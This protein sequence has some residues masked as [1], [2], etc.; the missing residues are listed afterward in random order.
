M[1]V[2]T[3]IGLGCVLAGTLLLVLRVRQTR[4]RWRSPRVWALWAAVFFFS[5]AELFSVPENSLWV[6]DVTG[7]PNLARIV[8]YISV[9]ATAVAFLTL[10]LVWRYPARTAWSKVRGLLVVYIAAVITATVLFALSNVPEERPED[11]PTHY[12]TQPTVVALLMVLLA[13]TLTSFV[14][15]AYWCFTWAGSDDFADLPHLRV[16]LRLYG[17]VGVTFST[18]LSLTLVLVIAANYFDSDALGTVYKLAAY[19][20]PLLAV[21]LLAAA[22]VVPVWGRRR[23]A[24]RRWVGQWR[25]F[26]TLR[27]L[28]RTLQPVAPASV[29]VT[30]GKTLDPHHRVRR[31]M[32]ELNDWRTTLSPLFDPAVREA[33][34]ERGQGRG[35]AG[36]QLEALVEAA[37]L[38]AATREW[39]DGTRPSPAAANP[40]DD[41]WI[42]DGGGSVDAELAWWIRVARASRRGMPPPAS[43]ATA[44]RTRVG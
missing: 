31:M 27:S 37:Q 39:C 14:L 3:F 35:L 4:S 21:A 40:Q 5:T 26:V 43:T 38:R 2:R 6:G 44:D 22:L 12:A 18:W 36:E 33:A 16:G 32:I 28:H 1:T 11:F 42:R 23:L 29:M 30:R 10:A 7:I 25:A 41:E 19:V 17:S 13:V 9:S 24:A 8:T 20:L 15:L 34:E